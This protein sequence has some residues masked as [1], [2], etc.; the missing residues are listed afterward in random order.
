MTRC[1]N[2]SQIHLPE[3]EGLG[4]IWNKQVV[5]SQGER[6]LEA[7]Q[8]VSSAQVHLNYVL[9][10]IQSGGPL[11]DLRVGFS[12]PPLTTGHSPGICP[13]LVLG[14]VVPVSLSQLALGRSWLWVPVKQS[15]WS[16]E[17]MHLKRGKR[18]K[19]LTEANNQWRQFISKGGL[20]AIPSSTIL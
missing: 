15:D 18:K 13:G 2:K 11:C 20:T 16:W 14:L 5:L 10:C 9:L 4:Y 1:E 3:G 8:K 12:G 17:G 7:R 6:W 19:K